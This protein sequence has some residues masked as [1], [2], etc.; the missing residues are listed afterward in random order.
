MS[1]DYLDFDVAIEK[2]TDGFVARV[3]ASPAGAATAPFV[4]PFGAA[5]LAQFMLAVGPARVS[6]RR[7]VP[8]A[9]RVGDV[10]EYGGRLG[11]AL[12]AGPVGQS[13]RAGLAQAEAEGKN[14]RI[15]LRLDAVPELDTVPWE[16][17][18]DARLER[19]LTLSNQT[20]VVRLIDALERGSGV[21]VA[22][23]LRVLV[24]ISSPVDVP[25]LEV[26]RE[27]DLLKATTAD[28]V[29]TGL[30]ELDILDHATLASLQRALIRPYHVFHFVGHG[31]F[32][33]SLGEGVLVLEKDDGYAHRVGGSR[34]G[35]LLHDARD[36][37][38]AV[39][40][41][42][43][44]A[45][46]S[47]QSA[48]SG[49][50]QALIRQGLPAVVAMQ[51]EIS[52]RAA[53]VF[54]H[55]FYFYLTRGLPIDTAICEV[56]K[57][58]ATS[59]EAS[60]WGTAVLLR[61]GA[62]Q[63]FRFTT[64]PA[65]EEPGREDRW[66]SLY[67]AAGD[68]L[69]SGAPGTALPML[70]QLA[71][72]QPDYQDVR[73]MLERLR[74]GGESPAPVTSAAADQA[75]TAPEPDVAGPTPGPIAGATD[76][77]PG[78]DATA[79]P[80]RTWTRGRWR[81][82]AGIGGLIAVVVAGLIAYAVTRPEG[83]SSPP[84][85]SAAELTRACGPAHPI[86]E[87]SSDAFRLACAVTPP[88]IDGRYDDWENVSSST[89]VSAQVFPTIRSDV[90]GFH[91]DWSATW[92]PEALYL[93]VHVYDA[94]ARNVDDAQPDQFASGDSVSFEFGPN[95]SQLTADSP[96]RDGVD[97]TVLI[98]MG[99]SG[100]LAAVSTAKDGFQ[101]ATA[102]SS[103]ITKGARIDGGYELEAKVPWSVL[104]VE[105]PARGAVFRSNLDVS[106]ASASSA[107]KLER[108]ISSNPL[109]TGANQTRP[110]TWLYLV[111]GDA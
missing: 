3:S 56:R 23:P 64:E 88:N 10:R 37:Q 95:S 30:V 70:E 76:T 12:F 35:T 61:S 81:L 45:R 26:Q 40:N 93:H 66:Q 98:G 58:M 15:R 54:S 87:S 97:F 49:V 77:G 2:A 13:F 65:A 31:G 53:L 14:L 19:F 8:A 74:P 44:G 94:S 67:Q 18:Y 36:L 104:G 90:E 25:P 109:R 28:L 5:E 21:S 1:R 34:L 110:G 60:E 91:A 63:P 99:E 69:A 107:W 27:I 78:P 92:D 33:T 17:L 51:T 73:Q 100:P 71:A 80:R 47:G 7:L 83:T 57:A 42:C 22:A 72:E 82:V 43:E 55:E 105:S 16:Y 101:P 75:A 89:T 86:R 52:D 41:S 96:L 85:P 48:F 59:D 11:D 24:M 39:L 46:T 62:E 111:L 103:I 20:P 9:A 38:L 102:E 6:S 29:S 50:A 84:P 106:D 79:A 32:D 4:L 68:A 108:M